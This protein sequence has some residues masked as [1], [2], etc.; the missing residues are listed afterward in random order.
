MCV[1][2]FCDGEYDEFVVHVA[3]ASERVS[4]FVGLVPKLSQGP[5]SD[6]D[7]VI[8]HAHLLLCA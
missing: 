8:A 1:S 7:V 2:A 6:L 3:A 5:K 4:C